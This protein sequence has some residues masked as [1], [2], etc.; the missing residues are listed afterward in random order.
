MKLDELISSAGRMTIGCD[1]SD[2][3]RTCNPEINTITCRAQEVTPGD[4]FVA[5]KGFAADGHDYI[6]QA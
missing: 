3:P 6:D 2:S 1:G 4:V 5:I